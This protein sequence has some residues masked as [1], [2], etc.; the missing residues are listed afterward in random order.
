MTI[1]QILKVANNYM[2]NNLDFWPDGRERRIRQH[3][4]YGTIIWVAGAWWVICETP[5]PLP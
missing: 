4:R 3:R 5:H 1:D 2:A